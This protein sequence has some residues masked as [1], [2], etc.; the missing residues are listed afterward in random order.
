M[1]VL[2]VNGC[3]FHQH[4]QQH[5]VTDQGTS[6]RRPLTSHCDSHPLVAVVL[7][8]TKHCIRTKRTNNWLSISSNTTRTLLQHRSFACA[9]KK[10]MSVL[11]TVNYCLQKKTLPLKLCHSDVTLMTSWYYFLCPGIKHWCCLTSVCLSAVAYIGPKS[12]TERLYRKNKIST[13]P[14]SHVTRTPLS[15]SKVKG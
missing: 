11:E 12:R 5:R 15:S 14:T 8:W 10:R 1:Y 3:S 4:A 13:Q 9:R 7:A 2:S 6:D